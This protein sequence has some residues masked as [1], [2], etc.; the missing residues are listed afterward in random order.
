MAI[1]WWYTICCVSLKELSPYMFLWIMSILIMWNI[2]QYGKLSLNISNVA[3]NQS[4]LNIICVMTLRLKCNWLHNF[5]IDWSYYVHLHLMLT[6]H[7]HPL[8]PFKLILKLQS[9]RIDLFSTGEIWV[10]L[11][12]FIWWLSILVEWMQ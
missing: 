3:I 1:P 2:L 4:I 10:H 11:M 12:C 5:L 8:R 7:I 6:A 9:L